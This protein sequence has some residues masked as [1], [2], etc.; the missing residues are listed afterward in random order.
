MRTPYGTTA[1]RH[2][3]NPLN[4]INLRFIEAT[5]PLGGTEH[6]EFQYQTAVL[7]ASEPAREV[8]AGFTAWDA[9]LNRYNTF[10]WSKQAWMLGPGDLSKAE[11]T[12]WMTQEEWPG[13]QSYSAVPH[14]IK[15]PLEARVWYAYPGQTAG[16]EFR[17]DWSVQPSRV[18]RVLD[19]GTSQVYKTTYNT[20]GSVV[21]RTDPMGR[22]RPCVCA[23]V[24][25]R[26]V[27]GL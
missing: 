12:H 20:H 3:P 25:H 23:Q 19:D 5:D 15:K 16:Q 27:I 21:T 14:S 9:D 10:Y 22:V 4:H 18:G 11:V 1:F 6:L 24:M 2:E 8:P 26:I 17:I 13:W 7:A